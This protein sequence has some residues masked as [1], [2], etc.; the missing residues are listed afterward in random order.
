MSH[1]QPARLPHIDPKRCTGCGRCVGACEPHLLSLEV[2]RWKKT[3][4]LNGPERCTAC[5]ACAVVC[6]FAA[7]SLRRR[8]AP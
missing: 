1:S 6:P 4:V 8:Q 2:L 7:I 5:S 3:A